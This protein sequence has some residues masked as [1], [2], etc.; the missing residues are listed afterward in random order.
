MAEMSNAGIRALLNDQ[1]KWL[2]DIHAPDRALIMAWGDQ[3]IAL[4]EDGVAH[5]RV[6]YLQSIA[7]LTT[8]LMFKPA[9]LAEQR[10]LTRP[11]KVVPNPI[12][13][14]TRDE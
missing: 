8:N 4:I 3:E 12:F 9:F 2:E 14:L 13:E 10:R 6:D 5:S 1:A 7:Q 11:M